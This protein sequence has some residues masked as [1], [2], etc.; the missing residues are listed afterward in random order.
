MSLYWYWYDKKKKNT[1]FILTQTN[2]DNR[3]VDT[4]LARMCSG[5]TWVSKYREKTTSFES[6]NL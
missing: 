6:Y 1:I 4:K 5:S 3:S 2:I